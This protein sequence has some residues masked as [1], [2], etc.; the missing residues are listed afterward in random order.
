MHIAQTPSRLSGCIAGALISVC[1]L[2][3]QAASPVEWTSFEDRVHHAMAV[4]PGGSLVLYGGRVPST[5]RD[6]GDTLELTGTSWSQSEPASDPGDVSSHAMAGILMSGTTGN[7]L[8]FGG[9]RGNTLL[10]STWVY[11]GSTWGDLRAVGPSAR[12]GH[13]MVHDTRNNQ[14]V[15]FGGQSTTGVMDDTWSYLPGIGWHQIQTAHSPAARLD[16][17]MAF[18]PGATQ[19]S[20]R[21][22]MFGG[23]GY[24]QDTWSFDGVDWSM[25]ASGGPA[26]RRNMALAWHT[27]SQRVVMFGG[28]LANQTLAGDTWTF[29]RAIN[30]WNQE[31]PT[32][33]P[34]ARWLHAMAGDPLGNV[35]VVGG[36]D[37]AGNTLAGAW[38]W[39]GV[40]WTR[41]S[42]PSRRRASALGF[43][44][45]GSGL[46]FG[47]SDSTTTVDLA[48]SWRLDGLTWSQ[49]T[50]AQSPSPRHDHT[51]THD[52]V[53][54]RILL[55]GG[56]GAGGDSDELWF[57]NGT[58]WQQRFPSAVPPNTAPPPSSGRTM[59]FDSGRAKATL[60]M[61]S[62]TY[63]YDWPANRW[64]TYRSP[65]NRWGM[66]GVLDPV[67]QVVMFFGGMNVGAQ[68]L[69]GD[70]WLFDGLGWQQ[71]QTNQSPAP[72]VSYG[73]A[74]DLAHN[75]AVLTGGYG[76]PSAQSGV[77]LS[78]TWIWDS[79]TGNWSPRSSTPGARGNMAM[80]YDSHNQRVVMFGGNNTL[81]AVNE[82]WEW[83]GAVWTQVFPAVSPSPRNSMRMA[84]DPLL[85]RIVM[86]G[87]YEASTPGIGQETWIYD[88]NPASR[89]WT[90]ITPAVSPPPSHFHD[91]CFDP[92]SGRVIV[93]GGDLP[94][95]YAFAST[96]SGYTWLPIASASAPP[97]RCLAVFTPAPANRP[98]LL[99]SCG[100]NSPAHFQD[101]W[102]LAGG[103]WSEVS[104]GQPDDR[105]YFGLADDAA[106]QRLVLFGG[107]DQ[108]TGE[109]LGDTWEWDGRNWHLC[110]PMG[111]TPPARSHATLSYDSVRRVI[112]LYGGYVTVGGQPVASNDTWEWNGASWTERLPTRTP[113]QL[114][115]HCT[116]FDPVRSLTVVFGDSGTWDYGSVEPTRVMNF[117]AGCPGS[118][119]VPT[120]SV[121]AY[122]GLWLGERL[123]VDLVNRPAGVGLFVWGF[124]R[125]YWNGL[126]LPVSLGI[127]GSPQCSLLTSTEVSELLLGGPRYTSFVL[128][129]ESW[130]VGITMYG[131]AAYFDAGLPGQ[132]VVST[133]ALQMTFGAK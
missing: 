125:E 88:G 119:G 10:G 1:S 30:T 55:F 68:T 52:S 41:S 45:N 85:G 131:Q 129:N 67:R 42:E 108:A 31:T 118:Q 110:T 109:R 74:F 61:G 78:D 62:A 23:T 18:D 21:V 4:A 130:I 25:I 49:L 17:S 46:L 117:G 127:F 5:G 122:S 121:P 106:R 39:N 81:I 99:L 76:G 28:L 34:T 97:Q 115:A 65:G 128:P 6:L 95:P 100:E 82:T 133:D 75:Q 14:V 57:W 11:D 50:P 26:G 102:L 96:L 80:T 98:G 94:Y 3:A 93:I 87:G 24:L 2:H 126:S 48:D 103:V 38:T 84:F 66:T 72:R 64:T 71:S 15:L 60:P 116:A 9:R 33:A 59:A 83:D 77:L 90:H 63:S 114:T 29:D 79:P 8:L 22:L 36:Q 69:L 43:H 13:A 51:M 12:Y 70:T 124:S 16:H 73:M 132:P 54:D 89:T 86:F 107:V 7:V 120:L 44:A 32:Q 111:G 113:G 92:A 47:G 19:T 56:S 91:T 53:R 37:A 40:I 58:S 105:K 104:G 35:V 101:S 20:G 123:E 112:V 27:N